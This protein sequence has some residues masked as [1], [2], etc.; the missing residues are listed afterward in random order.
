MS[1]QNNAPEQ[2]TLAIDQRYFSALALGSGPVALL[3]HGFPDCLRTFDAQLP[4]LAAAGYRAVAVALPGYEPGSQRLD[5]AYDQATLAGDVVA[6]I[7]ALDAGRVH[8]IGHD[9]GAAIGYAV[10]A[11]APQCLHTLTA[12][13]VPHGGRFM[14]EIGAYPGQLRM[15]WYMGFFQL[16]GLPEKVVRRRE[17]AFLRRLWRTWS[18]GWS[19]SDK[20]FDPVAETF[21]QPGVVEAALAYYRAAVNLRAMLTPGKQPPIFDVPVPT[22][23]MTGEREGCIAADVFEAMSRAEDF[24]GGLEVQRVP[25]AGHFLHREQP[26]VVNER[27]IAWLNAH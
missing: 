23:A 3:L 19:F 16:P 20:D 7:D 12:M 11:T 4:A 18:P 26:Q 9:W 15:S 21:A 6:I 25:A 22:L 10:A 5:G 13:A 1:Q 17:F 14:A 27:I 2:L 8:L 24:S